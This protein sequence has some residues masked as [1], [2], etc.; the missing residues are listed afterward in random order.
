MQS[1][2]SIKTIYPALI[3]AQ[4]EFKVADKDAENPHF[5]S[6]YADL[7]NVVAAIREALTKHKLGF[8]QPTSIVDGKMILTTRLIHE[9]GE[10]IECYYPIRPIADTPQAFG[11]ALTYAKRY[12]LT[13]L[14]GIV[15]DEDD[16]GNLASSKNQAAKQEQKP[17]QSQSNNYSKN[18][19]TAPAKQQSN[20]VAK[21][22]S[23][24]AQQQVNN[25]PSNSPQTPPPQQ[26]QKPAQVTEQAPVAALDPLT[27]K[28]RQGP[29][30]QKG[31]A[32]IEPMALHQ[33]MASLDEIDKKS[34]SP[35]NQLKSI[36]LTYSK[37]VDMQTAQ[38]EG[39]F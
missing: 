12:S 35:N 18:Q 7:S 1:S 32:D 9:S 2:E 36:L 15:A 38:T 33:H 4:A 26:Q 20:N 6:K 24:P 13:S 29:F 3:L 28:F 22:A 30:P 27:F 31:F 5:K 37:W 17:A 11:S 25:A 21:P 39:M 34:K 10:Y 8:I 19:N 16:D 23:V 14:L